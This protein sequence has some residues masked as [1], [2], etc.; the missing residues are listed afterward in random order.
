MTSITLLATASALLLASTAGAVP[1]FQRLYQTKYR[2]THGSCLLCHQGGA[3]GKLNDYGKGFM[4]AGGN[5]KAFDAIAGSDTDGDGAASR[6]E[7]AAGSNPG[8]PSSTPKKPG[9]W[10]TGAKVSDTVPVDELAEFFPAAKRFEFRDLEL[11]AEDLTALAGPAGGPLPDEDKFTTLYFPVD[12]SVTPAVR[13]GVAIFRAESR[14]DGLLLTAVALSPDGKI[15]KA[16][17]QLLGSTGRDSLKELGKQLK[18]KPSDAPLLIGK[19]LKAIKGK[20]AQSEA[21]ARAFRVSLA[22]INRTLAAQ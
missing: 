1:S 5:W 9:T 3:G 16:W 18:G 10:L 12:E 8:D 4:K 20:K 14:P 13:A 11:T 21:G 15:V 2:V 17:G 7:I 19:D 6:D 22:I